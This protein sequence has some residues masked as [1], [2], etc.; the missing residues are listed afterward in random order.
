M[1]AMRSFAVLFLA[2]AASLA[3]FVPAASAGQP[4][5]ASGC[6]V[7]NVGYLNDLAKEY[8]RRNP[9]I[10][11]LVRG[12]GSL[13]G[14]TELRGDKTD[15]AAS[16]KS[17][18]PSDPANFEFVTVAWDALVFIVNKSNPVSD[19]TPEQVRDIYDGRID[20]WKSLGGP[21]LGIKSYVSTPEGM[22]GIG[23]ALAKYILGGREISHQ[24][25]SVVMASSVAVWEQMVE[26][27]PEGFASTGFASARKRSVKML[28]V[29]GVP[30][31][32]AN[33][34]SGKYPLRRRLYLVYDKREVRPEVRKFINYALGREGQKFI[35]GLGIPSLAEIK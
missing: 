14:I 8:E 15:F 6:S 32:K 30:P 29:N 20:N 24:P 26:Q 12:G 22:G 2:M 4:M 7:S 25:N 17:K 28:R 16:C 5:I 33:I 18:G 10:H 27:S 3:T 19:I 21:D 11:I 35:G 23:E 34:V 9:G 31:T 13:L 1:H